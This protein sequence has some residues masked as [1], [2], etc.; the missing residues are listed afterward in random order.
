MSSGAELQRL[1]NLAANPDASVLVDHYEDDW[2]QLWWARADGVARI[3]RNDPE[4][5][6]KLAPL[7]DKY[8]PYRDI[9]PA[10]PV[11]A[12]AVTNWSTWTG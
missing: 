7:R 12:I 4:R 9:P 2:S 1:R 3:I 6:R 5:S 8:P 10:G 11:V